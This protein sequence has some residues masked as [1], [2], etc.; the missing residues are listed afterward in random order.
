MLKL[1]KKSIKPYRL[2]TCTENFCIQCEKS[3]KYRSQG[4]VSC[5]KCYYW[6]HLECTDLTKDQFDKF[7]CDESLIWNCHRWIKNTCSSCSLST[8][9]KPKVQCF[10]CNFNFHARCAGIQPKA[11]STTPNN[12]HLWTCQSCISGM[13]PFHSCPLSVLLDSIG[14]MYKHSLT[15]TSD[16][17]S[18]L[19]EFC[20]ICSKKTQANKGIPCLCCKAFIHFK[21][22]LIKNPSRNFHLFKNNWEC[23]SYMNDKFP[24]NKTD[25]IT[26]II[27]TQKRTLMTK[28]RIF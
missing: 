8:H 9:N 6:F 18:T 19:S 5:D 16:K 25:D 11:L 20:T 22:S 15:K 26:F 7:S 1:H 14:L 27:V 3:L 23:L 28:L 12:Y 4:G 21:C 24:F 10:A 13:F 17:H 2:N